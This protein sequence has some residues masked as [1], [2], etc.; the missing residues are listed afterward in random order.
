MK[1]FRAWLREM[2]K[3][4]DGITVFVRAARRCVVALAGLAVAGWLLYASISPR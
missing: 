3:T 1:R 2:T 4:V